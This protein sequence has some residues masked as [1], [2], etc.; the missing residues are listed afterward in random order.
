VACHAWGS[1]CIGALFQREFHSSEQCVKFGAVL[2]RTRGSTIHYRL[3]KPVNKLA[4]AG[5][6]ADSSGANKPPFWMICCLCLRLTFFC[7]ISQSF[8]VPLQLRLS[9][10]R[11]MHVSFEYVE[12]AIANTLD[13]IITCTFKNILSYL[14]FRPGKK[15]ERRCVTIQ[16]RRHCSQQGT[17]TTRDGPSRCGTQCKTWPRGPKQDLGAGPIWA[18]ILWR[19]RVQSTVLRSW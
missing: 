12:R 3:E 8:F 7:K 4:L 2:A 15:F 1:F 6:T 10:W 18:V 5:I 19:H 13:E 17:H 16:P 9:L 11:D 14:L